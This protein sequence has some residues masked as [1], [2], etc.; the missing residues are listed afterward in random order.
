[1]SYIETVARDRTTA[2]DYWTR[3]L[4]EKTE[5]QKFMEA[6]LDERGIEP[7][8]VADIA[9]GA[10]SASL[11]LS[12][13]FPDA[14]FTLRDLAPEAIELAREVMR[15]GDCQVG[16]A[17]ALDLADDAFDLTVCW[18]VLSVLSEPEHAVR[19]LVRITK[20]GGLILA[21]SLFNLDFDADIRASITDRSRPGSPA[22]EYNTWCRASV[23]EWLAGLPCSF[24][25]VP[26]HIGIDLP[27]KSR[28]LGTFTHRG[29]QISAG[30]LMNW[31]V[32]VIEK[33]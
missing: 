24:E 14:R 15:G 26:F 11:H 30:Y 8:N 31:G 29:L 1:M 13:K 20:P 33:H 32:L 4:T 19:E 25:I 7:R 17:Y 6:M 10:G 16:S 12:R 3:S 27:R 22:Y 18:Q 23:E 21:S 9:C 5:Q 2:R 28:G